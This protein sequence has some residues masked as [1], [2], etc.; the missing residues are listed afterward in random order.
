MLESWREAEQKA[1]N[2]AHDVGIFDSHTFHRGTSLSLR[3]LNAYYE[4]LKMSWD[5]E[6]AHPGDA[7]LSAAAVGSPHIPWGEMLMGWG[8]VIFFWRLDPA[9]ML[10]PGAPP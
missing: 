5:A 8:T 10:H 2:L 1:G 4:H 3:G 6:K 7:L 9:G